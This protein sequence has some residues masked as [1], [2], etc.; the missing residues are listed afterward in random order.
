[1][2]TTNNNGIEIATN[3]DQWNGV[4][5]LRFIIPKN[6]SSSSSRVG[7]TSTG[8]KADITSEDINSGTG[9]GTGTGT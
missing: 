5:D 2:R 1:M 8:M 7:A 9:T 3:F 6:F 4:R